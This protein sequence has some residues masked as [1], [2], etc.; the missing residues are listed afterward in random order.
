MADTAILEA[1]LVKLEGA[2]YDLIAGDKA[3][4]VTDENGASV[5]Y[6][7]ARK[8]DLVQAINRS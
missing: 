1:R 6:T 8:I 7:T 5:K 3:V 2:Y 4:E